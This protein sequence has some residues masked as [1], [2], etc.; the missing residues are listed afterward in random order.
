TCTTTLT[1]NGAALVKAIPDAGS[2]FAGWTPDCSLSADECIQAM[3]GQDR[4]VTA[5]FNLVP[6]A[7]TIDFAPLG[8]RTLAQAPFTVSAT[9]T[10]AAT[11][12]CA[13][14]T[15]ASTSG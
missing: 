11:C 4:T 9:A 1:P 8:N 15:A 12:C 5:T 3:N 10:G 6:Q 13:T 14:T 7:Q 2:V